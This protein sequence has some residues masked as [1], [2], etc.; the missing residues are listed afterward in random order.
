MNHEKGIC[1]CAV[2]QSI[3]DGLS[4]EEAINQYIKWQSDKLSEH[5]WIMHYVGDDTTS[6]T[7]VNI[8]T[9]GL[10]ENYNH[11]DLQVVLQ[12][13]QQVVQSILNTIVD[14]IKNGEKFKDGDVIK[15]VIANGLSI[16]IVNANE[17][18]RPVLRIIFPDQS[19]NYDSL[20]IKEPYSLQYGDIVSSQNK[21]TPVKV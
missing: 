9:H 6:P 16:K 4:K 8:H 11:P 7:G 12:I 5:G 3:S 21:W 1:D 18:G 2:C 17:N 15:S 13:P 10:H 14:R 20:T 19:G